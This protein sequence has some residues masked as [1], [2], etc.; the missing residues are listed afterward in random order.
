MF[1]IFACNAVSLRTYDE[2]GKILWLFSIKAF[3]LY[4]FDIFQIFLV[5]CTGQI[6]RQ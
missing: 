4:L 6:E 3:L 2:T 5:V 1:L